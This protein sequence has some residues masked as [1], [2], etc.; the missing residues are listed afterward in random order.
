MYLDI[1]ELMHIMKISI[2]G[3][4]NLHLRLHSPKNN[5]LKNVTMVLI[6]VRT[7]YNDCQNVIL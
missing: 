6:D 1:D 2:L 5:N 4:V 3:Y 7:L